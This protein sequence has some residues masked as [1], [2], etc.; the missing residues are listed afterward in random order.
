MSLDL[1]L[2]A[3]KNL[4]GRELNK[5]L[6]TDRLIAQKLAYIMKFLGYPINYP[7]S[8]YLRGPYSHD[9][10]NAMFS[11]EPRE[12]TRVDLESLKAFI[13]NDINSPDRME[14]TGSLLYLIREGGKSLDNEEDLIL[15][16]CSLKPQFSKDEVKMAIIKIK[17]QSIR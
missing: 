11:E 9:L 13:Q 12:E 2:S 16:L 7:F 4:A 15:T 6:Y 10:A 17:S 8:W 14:L 5:G 1:I 3:F